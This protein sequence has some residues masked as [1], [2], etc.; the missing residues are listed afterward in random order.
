M[1]RRKLKVFGEGLKRLD[2]RRLLI[3]SVLVTSTILLTAFGLYSQLYVQVTVNLNGT[4]HQ[5]ET[6]S[7]TVEELLKELEVSYK[8]EDFIEPSIHTKLKTGLHIVWKEAHQITL[9]RFGKQEIVWTT[10]KTVDDF[11]KEQGM[12]LK[13]GDSLSPKG[14]TLIKHKLTIELSHTKQEKI[15]EEEIVAFSTIR[16]SD[17][18]LLKGKERVVVTGREGKLKHHYL[19][20]YVNGKESKRELVGSDV[21]QEKRDQIVA[22]GT[23]ASVSRGSY[24]FSPRRVLENVTLTAYAAGPSHTGKSPGDKGYGMTAS[25]TRATEGRTVSVD[26]NVIPLGTWIY[27]EGIG[28]RRAED[29]GGAVK[30]NKVDVYFNSNSTALNF[31]KK[32]GYKVY[33]IGKQKPKQE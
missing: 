9:N 26:P 13:E 6:Q 27:I 19:V 32:K 17:P 14:T 25:G 7:N 1:V 29:T 8:P 28:L 4:E 10:A 22:V 31:G 24:V 21:V 15:A 3:V 18:A 5:L 20:T 30:G 11:M 16:K 12:A 23:Q 33:I 2:R